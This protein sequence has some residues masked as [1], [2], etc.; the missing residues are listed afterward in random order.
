MHMHSAQVERCTRSRVGESLRIICVGDLDTWRTMR[1]ARARDRDEE[2][3]TYFSS[4]LNF[5]ANAN[6]LLL[7]RGPLS[8]R[9]KNAEA[10][11]LKAGLQLLKG[12]TKL[13]SAVFVPALH[14]SNTSAYATITCDSQVQI[15]PAA[16]TNW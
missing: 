7:S 6:V 5:C 8:N 2:A 10:R 9:H 12:L 15:E 16:Y 11:G 13:A 3:P 1:A 14:R 4:K